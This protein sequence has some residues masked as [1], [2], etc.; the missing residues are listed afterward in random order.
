MFIDRVGKGVYDLNHYQ[1]KLDPLKGS[2]KFHISI[3]ENIGL[4]VEVLVPD[5][6]VLVLDV[7]VLVPRCGSTGPRMWKYWSLD[8]EVLVSGNAAEK[9]RDI[10]RKMN[11][12]PP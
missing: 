8:V 11:G 7:K 10:F 2:P 6:K 3:G 9:F 1:K 4:D 12:N 5:V